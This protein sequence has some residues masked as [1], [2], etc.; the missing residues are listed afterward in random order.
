MCQLTTQQR[1]DETEE[2]KFFF[3]TLNNISSWSSKV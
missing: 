3:S 2:M 1:H